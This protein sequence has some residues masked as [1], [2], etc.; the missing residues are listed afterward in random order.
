MFKSVCQHVR[1]FVIYAS[2]KPFFLVLVIT[3][4]ARNSDSV[5]S[6]LAAAVVLQFLRVTEPLTDSAVVN[7]KVRLLF[8]YFIEESLQA[9]K[10]D[11]LI[12]IFCFCFQVLG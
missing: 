4:T 2:R 5:V 1:I 6:L 9:R 11:K 7:V 8:I 12:D 3:N 10:V